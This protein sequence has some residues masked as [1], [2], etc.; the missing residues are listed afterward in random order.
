MDIT[1]FYKWRYNEHSNSQTYG[2]KNS[3][4]VSCISV[5]S[6]GL[7]LLCYILG[8]KV[9]V[10]LVCFAMEVDSP[11]KILN[12]KEV[13]QN[14]SWCQSWKNFAAA[15]RGRKKKLSGLL[16]THL[17]FTNLCKYVCRHRNSIFCQ[18]PESY[19]LCINNNSL[20]LQGVGCSY[21]VSPTDEGFWKNYKNVFPHQPL[22]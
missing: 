6:E 17:V 1:S 14:H 5:L 12:D 9:L 19:R 21:P 8:V 3:C 11:V 4:Q 15:A 13:C 18:L 7:K 22:K 10:W 20:C 16:S 2:R